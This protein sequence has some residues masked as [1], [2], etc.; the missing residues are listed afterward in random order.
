[1]QHEFSMGLKIKYTKFTFPDFCFTHS[2]PADSHPMKWTIYR[3]SAPHQ[4]HWGESFF[5][6]F[7]EGNYF[8]CSSHNGV[9]AIG[10]QTCIQLDNN[11]QFVSCHP[12][13]HTVHGLHNK[14]MDWHCITIS[15]GCME[16]EDKENQQHIQILAWMN[17]WEGKLEWIQFC[18]SKDYT[19]RFSYMWKLTYVHMHVYVSSFTERRCKFNFV[20]FWKKLI[21]G[22]DSTEQ[23]SVSWDSTGWE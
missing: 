11:T 13:S 17:I 18:S 14:H 23:G 10:Y 2:C 15:E 21:A 20:S 7:L 4:L 8:W 3:T 5:F 6:S 16:S 22:E 12:A 1:M 19:C 9:L